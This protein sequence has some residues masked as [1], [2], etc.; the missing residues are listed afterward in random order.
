MFKREFTGIKL[1]FL[2]MILLGITADLI[3]HKAN[4]ISVSCYIICIT[5]FFCPA[6]LLR[7]F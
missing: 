5:G 3:C 1:L 6:S 7:R 4:G 2:F